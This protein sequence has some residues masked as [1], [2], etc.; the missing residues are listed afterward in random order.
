MSAGLLA[1]S[2]A[3]ARCSALLTDATLVSSSS[4]TSSAFHRR[5][6]RRISTARCRGGRCWRAATKARRIDS[7]ST[8]TSAGSRPVDSTRPSGIGSTHVASAQRWSQ[9]GRGGLG[10]A[11][12]DRERPAL[13]SLEHVE[14]DV[15][16]DAIQP[17]TQRRATLEP[18]VAAPGP[19][20]GV[21]HGVLGLGGRTEHAVAV[22]GQ[23]PAVL[24]QTDLEVVGR[25]CFLG[26]AFR[27]RE[28]GHVTSVGV[29]RC[30]YL[31]STSPS[32]HSVALAM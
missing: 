29:D 26:L 23:L 3:R 6:S 4:A 18:V 19:D 25:A 16:G 15:G 5:T 7:R 12:V 9:R 14:A 22:A 13:A 10:R 24:L 20:H 30:G 8:V 1:A 11:E 2:V 28:I 31:G 27:R 32:N 17:R 21:L